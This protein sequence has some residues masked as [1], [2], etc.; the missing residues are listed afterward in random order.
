MMGEEGLP[1]LALRYILAVFLP[2]IAAWSLRGLRIEFVAALVLTLVFSVLGI[3]PLY[4][5]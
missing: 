1:I 5:F 3:K 2:P 4:I